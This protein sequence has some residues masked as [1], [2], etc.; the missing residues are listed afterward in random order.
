[1]YYFIE[2]KNSII[3]FLSF[4]LLLYHICEVP[5]TH[6]QETIVKNKSGEIPLFQVRIVNIV[7]GCKQVLFSCSNYHCFLFSNV[8]M[9]K[10]I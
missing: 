3:T 6:T 2:F 8:K 4:R 9:L 10:T 5:W 7:K 1:M